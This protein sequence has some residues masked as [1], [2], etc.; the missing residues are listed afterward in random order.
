MPIRQLSPETVNRIAAGEVIERPGERGQGAGRERARRRRRRDRGRDGRRRPVAHPRHRRRRRHERGRPRA[1]RRA[2]RHLQARATRTCSTSPRSASAARRCPRSASIARLS[3][4][5][6]HARRR[7]GAARSSS[8]AAPR[9]RVRPA[10][11]N[12]GTSVEVRELFSATPARLKFLKSERAENLAIS[13]VVKRLAM[14]H[15]HVGFTLTTGERAGLKLHGAAARAGRPPRP[16][17]PH[18]GPR[19]P[20]RCAGR[21]RRARGRARHG[22][23]RPADAAPARSRPAVPV[24]QRPAR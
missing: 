24:R 10:A 5:R 19:V 7:R 13:E 21:R 2:A 4:S 15:P 12:P 17:R 6:A 20:G 9:R 3:I 11:L 1:R 23:C 18:H 14:A 8:I 16:P 22:L